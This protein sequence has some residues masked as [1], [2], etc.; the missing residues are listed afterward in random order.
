LIHPP[1][2]C[3]F[4]AG[5]IWSA[6]KSFSAFASDLGD[7]SASRLLTSAAYGSL[8]EAPLYQPPSVVTYLAHDANVSVASVA[9]MV[10]HLEDHL[11][12]SLTPCERA[13]TGI[14]DALLHNA[15]HMAVQ[16]AVPAAGVWFGSIPNSAPI[17]PP[18]AGGAPDWC[19]RWNEGTNFLAVGEVKGTYSS[20][21]GAMAQAGV[22]AMAGA[23]AL[24]A[25]GLPPAACVVPFFA[26]NG[27]EEKHGLAYVLDNGLPCVAC[28]TSL[29]DLTTCEGRERAALRRIAAIDHALRVAKALDG[30]VDRRVV[31]EKTT[32]IEVKD[33]ME[34]AVKRNNKD[35]KE[36]VFDGRFFLKSPTSIH[37]AT[38]EQT[39]A[40]QLNVF[41][42][43]RVKCPA[44]VVLP[45]TCV[46]HNRTA[47]GRPIIS[48]PR[49]VFPN[50]WLAGYDA[51][52]PAD[53]NLFNA[54][55]DKTVVAVLAMHA[56]GIVHLDLHP[57]N[58]MHRRD[59]ETGDIDV[60]IIDL[61]SALPRDKPVSANV[62]EHVRRG[63]WS[64]AYPD[65]LVAGQSAPPEV[66]WFFL[67][68]VLLA[69]KRGLTA[70]WRQAPAPV[71][72][73]VATERLR[74]LMKRC[75]KQ[76]QN[77]CTVLRDNPISE[78]VLALVKE[79]LLES[80]LEEPIAT[81]TKKK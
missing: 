2:V 24:L 51:G 78:A 65:L 73:Q 42:Q 8:T 3:L 15:M 64:E 29:C 17:R 27:L 12:L 19:A 79:G 62:L 74:E 30:L 52:V 41:E 25:M 58:T 53:A 47:D 32:A 56:A 71:R 22:T 70:E 10:A 18:L 77:C 23:H 67:T 35:P 6:N 44:V 54:W 59:P 43:L 66:D 4:H 39:L 81:A 63:V 76:L 5:V 40:Q 68:A 50:M 45:L 57:H 26:G 14:V 16:A 75:R 80:E 49:L 21:H 36:F 20:V 34:N 61:D 33:A 72:E 28:L 11:P 1:H 46:S 7:D 13:E 69:H 48:I 38:P 60:K 31:A 55:L 9:A 37:A